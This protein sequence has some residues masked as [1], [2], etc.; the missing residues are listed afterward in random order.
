MFKNILINK[1]DRACWHENNRLISTRKDRPIAPCLFPRKKMK[2]IPYGPHTP[3][4][5]TML[6]DI[7]WCITAINFGII[8]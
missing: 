8:L 3:L 6:L 1:Q 4:Y 2:G 5:S 7:S